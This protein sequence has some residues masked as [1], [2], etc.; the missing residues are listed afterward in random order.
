ML[1]VVAVLQGVAIAQDAPQKPPKPTQRQMEKAEEAHRGLFEAKPNAPAEA[2]RR[3]NRAAAALPRAGASR[4][5]IHRKTF[6]DEHI[7][8]RIARDRV[9]HA[10]LSTDQEFVRRA[11]LDATGQLPSAEAVREF[12]A[13]THP[14]KR[15]KLIDSLIAGEGF[16]EQ[17]GWLWGDLFRVLGRSGDG[18]QGHLF[19]FW[20]KEW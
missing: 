20:N 6:I 16:A 7:F 8:G 1:V 9:P 2:G 14:Q 11:Y 10:P 17:W 3:T 5:K 19:H 4:A 18:N 12:L 13:D 15:D